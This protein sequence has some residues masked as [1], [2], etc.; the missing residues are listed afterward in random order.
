MVAAAAGVVTFCG[1][2]GAYGNIIE[3]DHGNNCETAYAHLKECLVNKGECVQQGQQIGQVGITG[4]ATAPH[5]HYEVRQKGV[6]VN[7]EKWLP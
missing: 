4:N 3:I 2:H 7:P 1:R 5:L 6:P